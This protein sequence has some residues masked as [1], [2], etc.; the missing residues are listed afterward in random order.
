MLRFKKRA[1]TYV[2]GSLVKSINLKLLFKFGIFNAIRACRAATYLGIFL[3][4]G[5]KDMDAT[6]NKA[7]LDYTSQWVKVVFVI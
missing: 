4:H 1:N 6:N 3:D 7:R 2:K 5:N